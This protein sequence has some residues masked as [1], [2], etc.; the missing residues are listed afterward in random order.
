M[1]G[2]AFGPGTAPRLFAM[3]LGV[4][5]AAVAIF[6]F[7]TEGSTLERYK[8]RGPL[9]VVAAILFFAGSIRSVGLVITSFVTII[10]AAAATKDVRWIETIIW[11]AILTAFCAFLFPY[12]LNLPLQLWP[13]Y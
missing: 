9:F 10:I 6:G 1:R 12:A 11:A 7:L 2:F 13:R 4:T 3:L 8:V 5:G